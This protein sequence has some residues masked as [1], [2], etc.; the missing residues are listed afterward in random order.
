MIKDYPRGKDYNKAIEINPNDV[1]AINNRGNSKLQLNLL[2]ESIEDFNQAAQID[3]EFGLVYQNRGIPKALSGDMDEAVELGVKLPEQLA[4]IEQ[5]TRDDDFT[6][7]RDRRGHS[8]QLSEVDSVIDN[9]TGIK[10]PVLTM[11]ELPLIDLK[12]ERQALIAFMSRPFCRDADFKRTR[13]TVTSF[14][15]R[16]WTKMVLDCLAVIKA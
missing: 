14:V 7:V 15:N 3:P 10:N 8:N 16:M 13:E 4:S 11:I 12:E 1:K 5:G 6:R 9:D 2:E